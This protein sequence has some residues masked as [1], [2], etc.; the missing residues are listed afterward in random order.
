MPERDLVVIGA[1]AGGL[2]PIYAILSALPEGFRPTIV[3]VVHT[4]AD[5]DGVLPKV[6]ARRSGRDVRD[7]VNQAPLEPGAIYVAPAD[8]HVLVGR[9]GLRVTRG[10]RENG[11]RPAIDPLF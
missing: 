8:R 9:K 5:G 2:Q 7:A 4:R 11:F 3:I 6:I 1:S 10:P